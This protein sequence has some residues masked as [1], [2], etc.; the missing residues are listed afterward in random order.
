[1]GVAS[2]TRHDIPL[3]ELTLG[4]LLFKGSKENSEN[5]PLIYVN[6]GPG[7]TYL[8][9]HHTIA[10]LS[11]VR[12]VVVYDQA[13]S[14]HS[15]ASFDLSLTPMA[16]FVRELE[17]VLDY[18][19][20]S[21]AIL[22]GHS[23]GGTIAADF[24][25]THPSRVA[26]LILSSPLLSTKRWI[27]DA[28]FLLAQMPEAQRS[29]IQDQMNGKPVDP[30]AYETAEKMFYAR[31][32]CRLE[33]WP[34]RLL[35]S[36]S[37]GNSQMYNAMWGRSEFTCTGTLKNYDRFADLKNLS[38][39]VLL[40]CGRYDEARPETLAQAAHEIPGSKLVVFEKSAHAPLLEEPAAYLETM[41]DFC[42]QVDAAR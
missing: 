25:L 20:F 4:S 37:K 7:G 17:T 22:L 1:M 33:P 2:F 3:D 14:Y 38:M 11:D 41:H 34:P 19:D 42:A 26:G 8:D 12:D 30:Q 10:A 16:R 21:S 24:A 29:I 6:G 28:K 9:E 13:G 5:L 18:Y 32:L 40:S 31:H 15:P 39:P 27:E 35:E 23:F 36:F